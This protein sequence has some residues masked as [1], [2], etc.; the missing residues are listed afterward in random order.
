LAG[1]TGESGSRR[2]PRSRAGAAILRHRIVVVVGIVVLLVSVAL[3]PEQHASAPTTSSVTKGSG[4]TTT[5]PSGITPPN[6]PYSKG[7]TVGGVKCGPNVRQVAWSAYAPPCQPAWHGNNGG[8]TSRG[9]TATTIT[10]TYRAASSAQLAELLAL[11]PE[12]VIGTN[13]EEE[14]TLQHYINVFNNSFELYGRKVRLVPFEGK[15]DFITEDLGE[16]Q[17]Q[18]Q[19]DAVTVATS[20]KA[21]ADMS[22]VDS[23]ALY[24]TDLSRQ[25]VIASSLY[26]NAETWYEHDAPW[27]YTPG[28]NCTKNAIATAAILGKQLGGLP[29]VLA[30]TPS[31]QTKK[32][33]FGIIAPQNPEAAACAKEDATDLEKYGQKVADSVSVQFNLSQLINQSQQAVA[34]MKAD[35]VT[36]IIMSSADPITPRFMLQA[37]DKLN[38]H[39]E[40]WAQSYFAGGMTNTDSLI[41]LFPTDQTNQ[42]FGVGNKT[43][44]LTQEEAIKAFDVDQSHPPTKPIPSFVYTY[45]SLLQ[46][47]DALQAA[48]PDLTPTT[49]EAGMS[50]IPQSSPGGMLGGWNGKDGPFDPSSTYSVVKFDTTARNPLDGKDGAFVWCDGGRSFAYDKNGT[51]VPSHQQIVCGPSVN[52]AP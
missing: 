38:Y 11:V 36:T 18:A 27:E 16:D 34:A 10:I 35:G 28:P 45:Q 42:I 12:T 21:F 26:E 6:R 44:P 7:T 9:V 2:A 24:A 3:V 30:A 40:W 19:E 47:F 23:S 1:A 51:D 15:G 14:A 52:R 22:L 49:F 4:S 39:P 32:R 8:A 50:R 25:H 48:G 33:V 20:I 31:I 29:A 13:T 46:F 5:L 43:L 17:V 41:N 37:A